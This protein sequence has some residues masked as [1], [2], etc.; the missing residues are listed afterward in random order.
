[1][2]KKPDSITHTEAR[3]AKM[4]AESDE[5][6][7]EREEAEAVRKE[8]QVRRDA[9]SREQE[10]QLLTQHAGLIQEGETREQLLD[11]IRQMRENPPVDPPPT[12]FMSDFQKE[13]L[14]IEQ[15][16]GAAAVKKA[17]EELERNREARRK[18]EQEQARREGEMNP[19]HHP[20]PGMNE[21]FPAQNATLGKKK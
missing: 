11:R 10:D 1:M 13:Q 20:N 16:A 5:Q 14:R 12:R 7:M 6:T 4:E 21:Q 9:L 19:V 2:G 8:K 3:R 17:E 15:E 18:A